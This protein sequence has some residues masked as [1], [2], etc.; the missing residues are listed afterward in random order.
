MGRG[1]RF[2]QRL[3]RGRLLLSGPQRPN[4]GRALQRGGVDRCQ[5]P[6]HKYCRRQYSVWRGVRV[7]KRMLGSGQYYEQQQQKTDAYRAI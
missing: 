2:E 5:L 4:V 7:L 3:H 6:E 1:L